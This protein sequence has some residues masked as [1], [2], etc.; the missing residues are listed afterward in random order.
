[1][2]HNNALGKKRGFTLIEL[3]VVIAIIAILA[4]ILFPVFAQAREKARAI[5]CLSNMKQIGLGV[6]MYAQDY[7]ETFPMGRLDPSPQVDNETGNRYDWASYSWREAVGP[8]IKNGISAVNWISTDGKPRNYAQGGIWACPSA[9]NTSR[10]TYDMNNWLATIYVPDGNGNVIPQVDSSGN[11]KGPSKSL[12]FVSRPADK[13]LV[14]EKGFR[15][16]WGSPGRDLM[17][18]AWAWQDAAQPYFGLRGNPNICDEDSNNGWGQCAMMPR[19]RHTGTSNFVFADGHAKA[20]HRGAVNW[21]LAGYVP[22]MTG[23]DWTFDT[24]WDSPC[25]IYPKE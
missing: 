20:F 9:P 17:M 18:E 2:S 1:M 21:C 24:S 4:A 14:V 11:T 23:S 10:E 22:G 15:P 25:G 16:E 13:I 5:S 7:D 8:Y 12:A 19:Y 6:M 3:L